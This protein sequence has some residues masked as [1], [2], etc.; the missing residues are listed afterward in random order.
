[1]KN[2]ISES[3]LA[4]VLTTLNDLVE[5][6]FLQGYA[7]GGGMGVLYYIEPVLTY[8]FDVFCV[9]PGN[10]L[11]IDPSP[12]FGELRRR[13]YAFGQEDRVVI[14]GVPVQFIPADPGLMDEALAEA[15]PVEIEGVQTRIMKLEH[16]MANMLRLHRA[17]DRAKLSLIVESHSTRYNIDEFNK[18]LTR[19][20]LSDKWER[21]YGESNS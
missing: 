12:L 18:I 14:A 9:F 5:K 6:G 11:L 2:D 20:N 16:L 1:M 21:Y 10:G 7:I 15:I 13:G 8:D 19:H 17:K 3:P 4:P